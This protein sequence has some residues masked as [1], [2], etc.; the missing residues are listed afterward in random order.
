[1]N[2]Q[3]FDSWAEVL[4]AARNGEPLWYKAPLD[5]S[6]RRVHPSY[7]KGRRIR[8]AKPSSDADAFWA[9]SGH[10]DRF[11]RLSGTTFGNPMTGW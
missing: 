4:A 2:L 7:V 6:A 3:P 11:R 8:I 10:L 5:Y 1:M 9:D